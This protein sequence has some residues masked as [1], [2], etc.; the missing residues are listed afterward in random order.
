MTAVMTFDEAYDMKSR[1]LGKVMHDGPASTTITDVK[2]TDKW[3]ALVGVDFTCG[4]N[5]NYGNV[6]MRNGVLWLTAMHGVPD[7]RVDL[8][9]AP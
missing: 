2:L 5:P 7:A 9:D 3:F 4:V 8:R 1:L 6:G